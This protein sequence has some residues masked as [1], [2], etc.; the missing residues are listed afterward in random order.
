MLPKL[1]QMLVLLTGL[2]RRAKAPGWTRTIV[3]A[4]RRPLP[5]DETE[6]L[7]ALEEFARE[8]PDFSPVHRELASLYEKAGRPR[9]ALE[10][11]R[12]FESLSD[13]KFKSP[14]ESE[15]IHHVN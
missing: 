9:D 8:E 2:E 14:H 7:V 12:R 15:K 13:R 6:L 11:R 1:T 5:R 3:Q 10:S 4:L